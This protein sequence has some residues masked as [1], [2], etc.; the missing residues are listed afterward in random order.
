MSVY[1]PLQ[2]KTVSSAHRARGAT[3][4]PSVASRRRAK[5]QRWHDETTLLLSDG[6]RL[7]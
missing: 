2:R 5:R 3:S 1:A 7:T 4:A 6:P